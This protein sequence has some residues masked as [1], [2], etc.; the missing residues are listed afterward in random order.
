MRGGGGGRRPAGAQFAAS[1]A[2]RGV[3]QAELPAIPRL[4]LLINKTE[5]LE[6]KVLRLDLYRAVK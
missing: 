2:W 3:A 5:K 1:Q 4:W 6:R